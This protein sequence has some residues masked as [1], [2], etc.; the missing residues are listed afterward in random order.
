VPTP[1]GSPSKV[2]TLTGSPSNVPPPLQNTTLGAT[3][4]RSMPQSA[5]GA[6]VTNHDIYM[7]RSKSHPAGFTS[8]EQVF[9]H[10]NMQFNYASQ[11]QF[12]RTEEMEGLS[13]PDATAAASHMNVE[14]SVEPSNMNIE[15][16]FHHNLQPQNPPS[17]RETMH[18]RQE[19]HRAHQQQ[20]AAQ[21]NLSASAPEFMPM[22][23]LFGTPPLNSGS[24][25]P[26]F[27]ENRPLIPRPGN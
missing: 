9:R 13:R 17:F 4:L 18:Q 19:M 11:G 6:G 2:P 1:T 16:P 5:L 23:T 3:G 27:T 22:S 7:E 21:F 24:R 20:Q 26:R 14:R 10:D 25:P 8:P 12:Q 15:R